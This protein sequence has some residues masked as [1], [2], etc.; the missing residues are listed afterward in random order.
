MTVRKKRA[1]HAKRKWLSRQRLVLACID[2]H[3]SGKKDFSAH[4]IDARLRE[5]S[6]R[7]VIASGKAASGTQ[8]GLPPNKISQRMAT[9][10]KPENNTGISFNEPVSSGPR[11]FGGGNRCRRYYI[12]CLKSAK[13]YA[14]TCADRAEKFDK[15]EEWR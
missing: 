9:V 1:P 12:F 3:E 8:G 14:E 11:E 6:V 7:K 4:D 15:P 2:L 10:V 13:A 5:M